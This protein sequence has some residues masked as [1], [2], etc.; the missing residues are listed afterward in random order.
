MVV[1]VAGSAN[2]HRLRG[3]LSPLRLQVSP[4]SGGVLV[5]E[6]EV[7]VGGGGAP[8]APATRH[9]HEHAVAR[10]HRAEVIG[11]AEVVD[12]VER[13]QVEEEL[14]ALVL[15]AQE[16][17]S[18]VEGAEEVVLGEQRAQVAGQ[19]LLLERDA[20]E[21]ARHPDLGLDLAALAAQLVDPPLFLPRF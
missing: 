14:V 5:V 17:V 16:G 18:L 1:V 3:E 9:H 10:L 7:G 2:A 8:A 13:L 11:E 21:G 19:G 12:H 6:T 4:L 20:D 15:V